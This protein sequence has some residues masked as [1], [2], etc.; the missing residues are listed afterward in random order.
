MIPE[1]IQM[2]QV[3]QVQYKWTGATDLTGA[4]NVTAH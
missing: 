4:T 3:Q 1:V 2:E